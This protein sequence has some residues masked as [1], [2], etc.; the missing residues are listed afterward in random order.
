MSS[1]Y[2]PCTKALFTCTESNEASS[3][4]LVNLSSGLLSNYANSILG[5]AEK[6]S[7]IVEWKAIWL[8]E[9]WEML[10]LSKWTS[11]YVRKSFV[12]GLLVWFALLALRPSLCQGSTGPSPPLLFPF[13]LD[14]SIQLGDASNP[15]YGV[16][17]PL[18]NPLRERTCFRRWFFW[19]DSISSDK[20]WADTVIWRQSP[21]LSSFLC[22]QSFI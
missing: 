19:N 11:G 2:G 12:C 8:V 17:D 7:L 13:L 16:L 9:L 20:S 14:A 15:Q 5:P 6:L 10:V 3:G 18:D 1:H 22:T 21:S 4:D